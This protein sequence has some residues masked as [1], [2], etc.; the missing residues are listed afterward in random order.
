MVRQ[1]VKSPNQ[2]QSFSTMDPSKEGDIATLQGAVWEEWM[3]VVRAE[4]RS[5]L[6]RGLIIDGVGTDDVENFIGKQIGKRFR[7]TKGVGVEKDRNNVKGNMQSKLDDSILD[8]DLRRQTRDKLRYRLER[9]LGKKSGY[10]RFIHKVRDK[11]GTLRQSLKRDNIHKIREIK[12][13]RTELRVF[14]LPPVL[15]RYKSAKVFLDEY[16]GEFKPGEMMGPVIVGGN[17][18]LL[19]KEEVAVLSRGPKFTIR[20]ILSRERFL[21]ELE[22]A[23]VKLRWELKDMEDDLDD[24]VIEMTDEERAED[25]RVKEAAELLAAQSR[26]TFD[27]DKMEIDCRRQR[28]TDAKHNTR[29]ILPGPLSPKLE[30]E[31]E[32]RRMEWLAIFDAYLREFC[33]EDGVQEDNLTEDEAKG[34]KSLKKRVADGSLI[35]CETDKSG[36]FAIM[37][38]DEY[39]LAG[40]KHVGKDEEVDLD[41]LLRNQN[42]LNGHMSMLLKTFNAGAD[43][44]HQA[45]L[46]A[47][48]LTHSLS[49]APLYLLF[50]HHKGWTVEAGGPP[51]RRPVASAGGG[52]DDHLSETISIFLEPVANK[53]EGGMETTSTPD[54][55]SR[56]LNLTRKNL[57]LKN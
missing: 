27:E 29:V 57:S 6:L 19:S 2:Q 5:N 44:N 25:T 32:S 31:L 37:S 3:G 24:T 56:L 34:L 16:V 55:I 50:K 8:A 23:F 7:G 12:L 26:M 42:R 17:I 46:R 22:K 15:K 36:R 51:P 13:K 9:L 53:M 30:R 20:R 40:E 11:A 49:V 48:M 52:Q 14:T 33:D 39:L 10:K 4:E 21:I 54:F 38:Q 18:H 45:R 35:V 47:T 1:G 28:C 43:W 41:F